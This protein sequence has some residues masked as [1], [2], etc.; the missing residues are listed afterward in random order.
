MRTRQRCE[1]TFSNCPPTDRS[2]FTEPFASRDFA[3]WFVPV[4][5]TERSDLDC[6]ANFKG[7]LDIKESLELG[8]E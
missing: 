1:N 2:V 7:K 8:F 5:F 4:A 3:A 6:K